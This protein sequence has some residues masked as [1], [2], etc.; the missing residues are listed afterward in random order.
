MV[1]ET[2]SSNTLAP[3][4]IVVFGASGAIGRQVVEQAL[5]GGDE[6]TAFVRSPSKLTWSHPKLT[7]VAGELSDNAAIDAAVR[8]ASGVISALGPSLDRRAVGMP[9]V[10]GTRNIVEAMRAAAVQRFVGMATPSLRDPRD[11]RSL[12]GTIVP[13]MGRLG[14]PRAYRELLAMSQLVID[15][16]LDWTIARFTRPTNGP[17]K[18]SV[19]AGFLGRDKLGAS[20]TRADIATFLLDQLDDTR[21]TRSAPAI[22]N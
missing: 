5:N 14:L 17:A 16:D 13:I 15:S 11:G 12:L 22:S 7:L 3:R 10:E 6:V 8:G 2:P 19:R 18:G 4:R 20:I 1:T 9:L 21:F